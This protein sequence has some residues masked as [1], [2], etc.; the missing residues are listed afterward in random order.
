MPGM[1][2]APGTR[3]GP[4]EVLALVG[5]GGM[6]EVYRARDSRL[7][8]DVAIKALPAALAKDTERL[9]R[10]EREA[11]LLASL[12]HPNI[13]SIHGLEVAGGQRYL[14][15]EYVE[16]QTL[17]QRLS[18][19]ALPMGEAA[20]ICRDLAAGVEAAHEGGVVHR[21]LKPAN[22]MLTPAGVVKVLDFGLAK[23]GS[24]IREG[25]SEPNLSASPTLILDSTEAGTV[26][27]TAAYMSPEQARGKNVDRRTDIWSFGCLLY[28]C[29]CG[30]RVFEG[31]T[32]SDLVARILEREP[33]WAA[34]P[35]SVPSRVRD[36]LKRCLAKEPKQRLRDIGDARLELEQVLALGISGEITEGAGGRASGGPPA[37]ILAA[38]AVVAVVA[39]Q[40]VQPILRRAGAPEAR[41]FEI[42]APEPMVL[43]FDPV[44]NAISPDGRTLAMVLADS[45]GTMHLWVRP[46]NSFKGRELPGTSNVT[47][48]FWSPDSRSLAFFAGNK[49]MKITVAFGDP[50]A[51]A[52]VRTP[53]GGAWSNAGIILFAPTSNG[54]LYTLPAAGGEPKAVT[55]LDS[56]R[57]E[58]A[59][60]FPHFLPDGRHY[61]FTVLAA[62]DGRKSI[63]LGTIG[64]SERTQILTAESGVTYAPPGYLLF[65]RKGGLCAQRFDL[66]SFKLSGD[67][68]SLG[69]SP[70]VSNTTGSAVVSAAMDGTLAYSFVPLPVNRLAWFD[71]EGREVQ[72][73]PVPPGAYLYLSLSPDN[74]SAL[75]YREVTST[76]WELLVVDLERGTANR[77]SGESQDP[78]GC[79]WSPDG[80]RVAYL[81]G[82]GGAPQAIAVV[83]ADGSAQGE[84]VLPSGSNFRSLDGWTPDGKS[85][86]FEQLDP[87]TNMDL[88]VLPLEGDRQPRPYLRSPAN[89]GFAHVSPDGRWVAYN[90]DASGR[91]EGYVQSFPTPGPRYQVTTD[92]TGIWGW[93]AD[94]KSLGLIPPDNSWIRGVNVLPGAEF[95]VGPAQRIFK[96][97][98]D[99]VYW[100]ASRDWKR[101]LVIVPAG[102]QAK[103]SIR[104]VLNW[105]RALP[106]R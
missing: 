99:P 76:Q 80:K 15:L 25:G 83:P 65:T 13:A 94:G 53:R 7:G 90:S 66:G 50:E 5:A 32:V 57:H 86:V 35:A 103:P 91:N 67:P 27:G 85:L 26:L 58:T 74:R 100:G 41:R 77:L 48:P 95:R 16:G 106:Q 20:Q 4:Y 49:L 34:L 62:A 93:R 102:K 69:D 36:L 23:S 54:P 31:E 70:P 55:R 8:R 43:N 11:R 2:F 42:S 24:A 75:I 29:L 56:T 78:E 22:V 97:P 84:T 6:G 59:H 3:I 28:E 82:N 10:F 96:C 60:R 72:P 44:E 81:V 104:V 1:S 46:I 47:Q 71:P 64:E 105:T 33:D 9:A 45:A 52:D 19:G 68:I 87:G 17:A 101:L 37:W 88:W 38:V 89:E 18:H 79:E 98:Q 92:G 30:R 14:V 51:L 12:N 63:Q 39:T 61:L 73:I 21:D 40:L